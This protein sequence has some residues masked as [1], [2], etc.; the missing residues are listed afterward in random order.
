MWF[1]LMLYTIIPP[2]ITRVS[3]WYW[4]KR[5][6]CNIWMYNVCIYIVLVSYGLRRGYLAVAA[7]WF[8]ST[9]ILELRSAICR[10]RAHLFLTVLI[11]SLCN[12]FNMFNAKNG[13]CEAYVR[14][15]QSKQ[16]RKQHYAE[17]SRCETLEDV[18][19]YLVRCLCLFNYV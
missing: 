8:H 14:G 2:M 10:Q 11:V 16:L 5:T 19:T 6:L 1:S 12:R 3:W 4:P 13:F 17:L 7:W 18:K 9:A 15:C